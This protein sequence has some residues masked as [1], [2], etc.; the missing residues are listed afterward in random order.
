MQHP[1]CWQPGA[2]GGGWGVSPGVL[3]PAPLSIPGSFQAIPHCS[4]HTRG[5][6]GLDTSRFPLCRQLGMYLFSSTFWVKCCFLTNY[7]IKYNLLCIYELGFGE[8]WNLVLLRFASIFSVHHLS[9]SFQPSS[10]T[11]MHCRGQEWHSGQKLRARAGQG[12]VHAQHRGHD[13]LCTGLLQ[14]GDSSAWFALE[15][16][17]EVTQRRILN[18]FRCLW[19]DPMQS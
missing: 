9:P 17:K 1:E 11:L 18:L 13:R 8:G 5:R 3:L 6:G 7:E 14:Q 15:G 2:G 10:E 16:W 4:W 19:F 12:V